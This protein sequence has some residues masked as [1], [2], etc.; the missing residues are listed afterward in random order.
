LSF[1]IYLLVAV[2]PTHILIRLSD[3]TFKRQLHIIIGFNGVEEEIGLINS[4][5]KKVKV[6]RLLQDTTRRSIVDHHEYK[7]KQRKEE[8]T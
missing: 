3:P 1:F 6:T 5:K 8:T 4:I 2:P 7:K